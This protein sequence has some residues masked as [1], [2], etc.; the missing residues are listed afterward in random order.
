MSDNK[1]AWLKPINLPSP[2]LNLI[3]EAVKHQGEPVISSLLSQITT[4]LYIP[5]KPDQ[6]FERVCCFHGSRPLRK[7]PARWGSRGGAD[8]E[9]P[10]LEKRLGGNRISEL[11]SHKLNLIGAI[12]AGSGYRADLAVS[13]ESQPEV[14]HHLA[15]RCCQELS[16]DQLAASSMLFGCR[17]QAAGRLAEVTGPWS[18]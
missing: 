7:N 8:Q 2:L 16:T 11:L 15:L 12:V 9:T 17:F 6:R 18:F 5:L 13:L 10:L 14:N 1:T 3:S 4:P